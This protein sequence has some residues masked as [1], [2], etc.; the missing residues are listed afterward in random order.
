[1]K[2]RSPRRDVGRAHHHVPEPLRPHRLARHQVGPVRH[3]SARRRRLARQPRRHRQLDADAGDGLDGDQHLALALA[4]VAEAGQ[5]LLDVVEVGAGVDADADRVHPR[6]AVGG[7]QVELVAAD[8]GGEHAGRG[9]L[10][11]ELP[12]EG[13]R[14]LDVRH[15]AHQV[16]DAVQTHQTHTCR[17]SPSPSIRLTTSSP[18]FR[19]TGGLRAI[20]TPDGVPVKI[21][22]PGRAGTTARAARAARDGEDHRGWCGRPAPSR[23][24]SRS[25]SARSSGSSTSS[26]VTS[27]GPNGPKP[28]WD[29]PSENCGA[30]RRSA[31]RAR[32]GP[33]RR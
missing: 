11:P 13:R 31:S 16:V 2:N 17:S 15:V 14:R 29:L 28:G 27:Y 22:S 9:L 32:R 4:R 18:G 30:G 25:S 21:T 12:V 26:G 6:L 20:P 19:N 1:M 23:R 10:E 5:P 8:P 24:R 3:T 33:G 7:A